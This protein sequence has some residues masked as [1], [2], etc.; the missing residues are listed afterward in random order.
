V[1]EGGDAALAA[2]AAQRAAAT[3]SSDVAVLRYNVL[4]E[5]RRCSS[6]LW[7]L[8]GH[9]GTGVL[10]PAKPALNLARLYHCSSDAFAVL[11]A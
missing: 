3:L 7:A 9:Y 10:P 6:K 2:A 4:M 5:W 8:I 11:E 1:Q